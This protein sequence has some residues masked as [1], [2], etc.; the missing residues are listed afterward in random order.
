MKVGTSNLLAILIVGICSVTLAASAQQYDQAAEQQM[1]QLINQERAKTG[2]P[3]LKWD[4]RLQQA[5]RE[6]AALMA[7]KQQLSHQFPGEPLM[8]NRL[9]ATGIRLNNDAE[10]VAMD[11]GGVE[12][13]H[14]GLMGSPPHRTNILNPQYNAGGVGVVRQGRTLWITEDFAHEVP[15]RSSTQA[16]EVIAAA[17][18]RERSKAHLPPATLLRVPQVRDMACAMARRGKLDTSTPLGLS[19][20]RSDVAYTQTEPEKLPASAIKMAHE[21]TFSRFAVGACFARD[22][23]YP[24]GT[25][26]VVMTF[27]I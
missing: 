1:F 10:N 11:D 16:E 5:A 20:V 13:A 22:E 9:A 6:H 23:T 18:Q 14:Q 17:F 24:A 4:E 27:Y 7:Q 26:W 8:H 19:E 15:E 2:A 12:Q 21:P 25:F 3:A